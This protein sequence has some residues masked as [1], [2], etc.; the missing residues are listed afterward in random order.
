MM[1]HKKRFPFVTAVHWFAFKDNQVLLSRRFQ[2]GYMDGYYS[3]PAGH[4]D[5]S[6]TAREAMSREIKEEA[7][8][9]LSVDDLNFGHVMH[10]NQVTESHERIDFFFV[11]DNFVGNF[12][13]CEPDKCDQLAWFDLDNL[14]KKMV[15][16]V[17]IALEYVKK[18][19]AYS[20]HT[21]A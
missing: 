2:T 3:V 7:G 5:G 6:E 9:Q 20:E 15:E 4:V 12:K 11:T 19:I 16:Y 1:T 13:N 10:R 14:P 21:E 18:E 8:A 17:R